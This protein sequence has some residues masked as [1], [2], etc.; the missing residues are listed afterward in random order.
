M[1]WKEVYNEKGE[2]K[3]YKELVDEIKQSFDPSARIEKYKER[4]VTIDFRWTP[5]KGKFKF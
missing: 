5:E 4:K 1:T 2:R 3:E